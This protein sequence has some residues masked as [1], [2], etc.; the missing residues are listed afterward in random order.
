M[1]SDGKVCD[2]LMDAPYE[3][4]VSRTPTLELGVGNALL[5]YSV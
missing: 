4:V 2:G 5:F 1:E 3:F